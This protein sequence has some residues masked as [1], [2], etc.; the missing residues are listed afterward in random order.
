MRSLTLTS[1]S[2]SESV[3]AGEVKSYLRIQ[4]TVDDTLIGTMIIS[5]RRQCEN[6]IKRALIPSQFSLVMDSFENDILIPRPPLSSSST[7]IVIS[8]TN[9]TGVI[10]AVDSTCYSI[11]YLSEPG[12]I[13]L[14]YDSVWPSDVR[15][16]PGSVV[17]SYRCG[18]TSSTIPQ[19][20]KQW[21]CARVGAYYEHR[22]P[23][24]LD[25]RS[26][27]EIPRTF[28]DGLLDDL[29]IINL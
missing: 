4:T 16:Y 14:A 24:I 8:Y 13:R 25:G 23:L 15:N 9:F 26:L 28:I 6:L 19:E 7:D 17:I 22:E 18:Y 5:A 10:Q 12:H 20:V 21:I 29:R 1:A 2:S 27:N 11:D 3:T